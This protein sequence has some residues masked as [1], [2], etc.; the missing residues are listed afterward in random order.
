VAAWA[1]TVLAVDL[2]DGTDD[3]RATALDLLRRALAAMPERAPASGRVAMRADAG[4]FAGQL[5]R[6]AHDAGIAFAIGA[7][8][9]APLSTRNSRA[10]SHLRRPGSAY[11]AIRGIG[12]ESRAHDSVTTSVNS[13]AHLAER[14]AVAP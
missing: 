7:R 13:S 8:R 1:E 10:P 2:G 9:I 5:A 12:S 6:A 3:L 4:Y 11:G 14:V